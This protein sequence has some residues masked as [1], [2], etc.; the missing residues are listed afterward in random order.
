MTLSELLGDEL[1]EVVAVLADEIYFRKCLFYGIPK[2]PKSDEDECILEAVAILPEFLE[3][4][5]RYH[6]TIGSIGAQETRLTC[7]ND[8]PYECKA[9]RMISELGI[10]V[11]E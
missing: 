1:I 3:T 7:I 9:G 5:K 4:Y 2:L 8:E 10:E 11:C 6:E